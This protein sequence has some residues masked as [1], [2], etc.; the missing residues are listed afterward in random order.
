MFKQ[1]RGEQI[2]AQILN[3]FF[4][5]LPSIDELFPKNKLR[6]SSLITLHSLD[7]NIFIR[8]FYSDLFNTAVK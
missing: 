7:F 1:A 3:P 5:T 4:G 6:I 2:D 8:S